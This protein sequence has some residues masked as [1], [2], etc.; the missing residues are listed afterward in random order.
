MDVV[1]T[2]SIGPPSDPELASIKRELEREAGY[3]SW[4]PEHEG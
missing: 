1:R 3:A 2:V 4:E